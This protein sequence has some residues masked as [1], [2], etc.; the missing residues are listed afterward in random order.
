MNR[1]SCSGVTENG[2]P[3]RQPYTSRSKDGVW[4]CVRWHWPHG[5]EIEYTYNSENRQ[6][7]RGTQQSG[8]IVDTKAASKLFCDDIW[9]EDD[10]DFIDNRPESELSTHSSSDDEDEQEDEQEDNVLES[11]SAVTTNKK[12]LRIVDDDDVV[13]EVQLI[14]TITKRRRVLILG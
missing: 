11:R 10:E 8:E 14:T 13:Y 12:R 5:V 3:C 4:Y 2:V 1:P 9:S 7:Y 6:L